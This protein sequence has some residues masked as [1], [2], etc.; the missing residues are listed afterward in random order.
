[1]GGFTPGQ[2]PTQILLPG[3]LAPLHPITHPP[4]LCAHVDLPSPSLSRYW[5]PNQALCT[6]PSLLQRLA[7]RGWQGLQTPLGSPCPQPPPSRRP[8]S[9]EEH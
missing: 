1:M 5:P 8:A 2:S 4:Q 6:G 9:P 3:V 7:A